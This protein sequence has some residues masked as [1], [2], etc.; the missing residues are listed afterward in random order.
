MA[1]DGALS[2]ALVEQTGGISVDE[3]E[4]KQYLETAVIHFN[5]EKG[6]GA[7]GT[8]PENAERLPAALKECEGG[9]RHG[10]LRSLIMLPLKI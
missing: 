10:R 7:L 5:E 3:N 2:S 8:E 1:K 9:K 4:L 6:A